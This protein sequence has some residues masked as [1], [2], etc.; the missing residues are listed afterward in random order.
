MK[1][2]IKVPL[3]LA[4]V[5]IVVRIGLEGGSSAFAANAWEHDLR[6]FRPR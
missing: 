6:R 2:L 1:G 4:A 5:I 3:I